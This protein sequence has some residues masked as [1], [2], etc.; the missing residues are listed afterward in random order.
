MFVTHATPRH[1]T[2]HH[3]PQLFDREGDIRIYI[4]TVKRMRMQS[5]ETIVLHRLEPAP[6]S[7]YV[8]HGR[9]DACRPCR[10]PCLHGASLHARV[11]MEARKRS[12]PPKPKHQPNADDGT[13]PRTG[14]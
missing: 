14:T 7:R 12:P 3:H 6:P 8:Y 11:C 9:F 13:H 2:P 1:T 5:G 4:Y 10:C